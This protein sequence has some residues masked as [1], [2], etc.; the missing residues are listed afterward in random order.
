MS[1]SLNQSLLLQRP[2]LSVSVL[3]L[4][5]SLFVVVLSS[6]STHVVAAATPSWN[7]VKL[8]FSTAGFE[9]PNQVCSSAGAV[10]QDDSTRVRYTCTEED[11]FTGAKK[12]ALT[13]KILPEVQRLVQNL[14]QIYVVSTSPSSSS[15]T[16]NS[17][18]VIV[19]EKHVCN[20]VGA[21]A[22]SHRVAPGVDADIVIYFSALPGNHSDI[23]FP[24]STGQSC[25]FEGQ[26]P[27]PNNVTTTTTTT[28][29]T[30]AAATTDSM[31]RPLVGHVNVPPAS[32]R[33]LDGDARGNDR[34]VKQVLRGV[35]QAMGFN[36]GVMRR[37]GVLL[38]SLKP[39]TLAP[40]PAFPPAP[41]ATSTT[42]S[43]GTATTSAPIVPAGALQFVGPRALAAARAHFACDA[44]VSIP[45]QNSSD[46]NPTLHPPLETSFSAR[47]LRDDVLSDSCCGQGVVLSKVSLA[48]LEDLGFYKV[49]DNY[50]GV[51][52]SATSSR[53]EAETRLIFGSGA[54]CSFFTA[55]CTTD[56]GGANSWFCAAGGSMNDM[57]CSYSFEGRGGCSSK[58]VGGGAAAAAGSGCTGVSVS[59]DVVFMNEGS[60]A[61][62]FND[63]CAVWVNETA[64]GAAPGTVMRGEYYGAESRCFEAST[65]LSGN[66]DSSAAGN[67]RCLQSRCN[68]SGFVQFRV[69]WRSASQPWLTCQ[70]DG[71]TMSVEGY[72]G[73]VKCPKRAAFCSRYTPNW[74]VQVGGDGAGATSSTT[75]TM[76]APAPTTMTATSTA[77]PPPTAAP[78]PVTT[79]TA[80]PFDGS[81]YVA[82]RIKFEV[83]SPTCSH[84]EAEI[85]IRRAIDSNSFAMDTAMQQDLI[86]LV[87]L[88]AFNVRIVLMESGGGYA[89]SVS[90]RITRVEGVAPLLE[91]QVVGS[92]N[93]VVAWPKRLLAVVRASMREGASPC[94]ISGLKQGAVE[95]VTPK[96]PTADA[97]CFIGGNCALTIGLLVGI[98]FSFFVVVFVVWLRFFSPYMEHAP[99]GDDGDGE[100]AL[101]PLDAAVVPLTGGK[102]GGAGAA[103][104]EDSAGAVPAAG[105]GDS[106]SPDAA[107]KATADVADNVSVQG[108]A[109]DRVVSPLPPVKAPSKKER[110]PAYDPYMP[111]KQATSYAE[112]FR[113]QARAREEAAAARGQ[114]RRARMNNNNSDHE[115]NPLAAGSSTPRKS[116]V[117]ARKRASAGGVFDQIT[118]REGHVQ[119]SQRSSGS[120]SNE[121]TVP[122]IGAHLGPPSAAAAFSSSISQNAMHQL[123]SGYYSSDGGGASGLN[124]NAQSITIHADL[125]EAEPGLDDL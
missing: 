2:R 94:N 33:W 41:N 116:G 7:P 38:D 119:H 125:S 81:D 55:A 56:A 10:V 4:L 52:G 89:F 39:A 65:A 74:A 22:A 64:W 122:I 24:A 47:Y 66:I 35:L 115:M 107:A 25:Y 57:R 6:S 72:T 9:N 103:A 82:L 26:V 85:L 44:L 16:T 88:P 23:T 120:M 77:L 8:F 40:V 28:A 113:Q 104:T 109:P 73:G 3:L 105:G 95:D 15:S 34:V 49:D 80:T 13:F 53:I 59:S 27:T 84:A 62:L 70:Q 98:V 106:N 18:R 123:Q 50:L 17:R 111:Q 11:V 48:A 36:Y 29:T 118:P 69:G 110:T 60:P 67:T 99:E 71:A 124:R 90:I 37:R 102:D 5:M 92:S 91:K 76:S 32:A 1:I 51:G 101:S 100:G 78:L 83:A 79:T 19:D 112:Y 117:G 45:M 21:V 68:G 58:T 114:A 93:R 20:L 97:G 46:S 43:A 61:T 54:S 86:E 121:T 30:A 63:L 12:S 108:N 75:S 96:A 42:T 31:G 14:L 87:S